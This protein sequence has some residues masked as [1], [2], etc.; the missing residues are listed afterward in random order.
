MPDRFFLLNYDL[1]CH[2][3]TDVLATLL[4]FLRIDV[5]ENQL[6]ELSALV[7][8]PTTIG[9]FKLHGLDSLDPGDVEFVEALGFETSLE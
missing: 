4:R 2:E 7:T 8:P 5:A 3:P 1:L 6:Q 9:R